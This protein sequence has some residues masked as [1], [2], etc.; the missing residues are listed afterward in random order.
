M[1]SASESGCGWTDSVCSPELSF[2]DCCV[3]ISASGNNY[4]GFAFLFALCT[5]ATIILVTCVDVKKGRA[6]ALSYAERKR[7][8]MVQETIVE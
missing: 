1:L 8:G 6:D 7:A 4:T 2:S 3:V 5:V